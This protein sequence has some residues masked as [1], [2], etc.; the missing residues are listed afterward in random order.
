MPNNVP[1]NN[2]CNV[3]SAVSSLLKSEKAMQPYTHLF[4]SEA[5][6]RGI[7]LIATTAFGVSTGS[8]PYAALDYCIKRAA[9]ISGIP[10]PALKPCAD[11]FLDLYNSTFGGKST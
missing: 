7:L 10:T 8:S 2:L 6:Q 1:Q 4:E 11:F 5:G 3:E 9:A